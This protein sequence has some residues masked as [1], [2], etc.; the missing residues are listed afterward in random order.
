M[1][2]RKN[3]SLL[4][5]ASVITTEQEFNDVVGRH[6]ATAAD[7]TVQ[8]VVKFNPDFVYARFKAIGC[9]CVDGPNANADGFPYDQFLDSRAGYG[10]QSFIGK[11]AFVEH[12]SDNINNAI[13]NL[14]SA[15]LNRF[16]TSKYSNKEWQL[17]NGT[18]RHYVL[19]NR[20][21]HEDGSVEVLMAIDRQ[22]S[23]KIA[24]MLETES[25]VGCSMGTNIDYS[26]CT[27]CGNRAYVEENYC[28]HIKFSKG[29]NVLVP[30][31]QISELIKKG[32]IKTE[33]LPFILYR[34]QDLKAVASDVRRMVY[35]KAFEVNYGLSFFELS[36]VANP[37]FHRGYKLEKIASTSKKSFQQLLPL[38]YS[39]EGQPIEVVLNI[40]DGFYK[41]VLEAFA[42][43]IGQPLDQWTGEE[44]L[45]FERN[46]EIAKSALQTGNVHEVLTKKINAPYL[47]KEGIDLVPSDDAGFYQISNPDELLTRTFA[48]TRLRSI[49]GVV[50]TF[51]ESYY[52]CAICHGVYDR[53]SHTKTGVH[54]WG[55]FN[56]FSVCPGCEQISKLLE[57]N[58][59]EV[60]AMAKDRSVNNNLGGK[61]AAEGTNLPTT[62][63][64]T[65]DKEVTI[66]DPRTKETIL[67]KGWAAKGSD[68]IEKEK[69][70]RPM[71]TIFIDAIVARKDLNDR[72]AR[73]AELLKS[74]GTLLNRTKLALDAPEDFLAEMGE[75]KPPELD[76]PKGV[77][78]PV[79]PEDDM[80]IAIAIDIESEGDLRTT[81]E[82]TKADLE[83]IL[84]DLE[85]AKSMVG[86]SEGEAIDA[87][88]NKLRWGKRQAIAAQKV[89][90]E[91]DSLIEDA[92]SA[93]EDA[94]DK[95]QAACEFLY[96]EEGRRPD[97]EKGADSEKVEEK[98]NDTEPSDNSGDKSDGD[99]K[100]GFPFDK[101]DGKKYDNTN[102]K[103]VDSEGGDDM[104]KKEA[105]L[106]LN[107]QNI[108]LLRDLRDVVVGSS[109][110]TKVAA[111]ETEEV[112][113]E[114]AEEVEVSDKVTD[115]ENTEKEASGTK[116]TKSADVKEAAAQPPTGARDPGDY[117][118]PGAIETFEMKRWWQDMYPEFEKMKATE[119]RTELNIPEGKVELLT[120]PLGPREESDPEVGKQTDAPT[121]FAKR[122]ANTWE[123]KKS[124]YGVLK[125]AED[126]AVEAFTANFTDVTDEDA[127]KEQF[128]DFTSDAYMDE[129]VDTVKEHGVE[130]TRKIMNGKTAQ[131]EGITPGKTEKVNPLY[132]TDE[133]KKNS[134]SPREGE[135]PDPK[136]GHGK[137][138]SN[139]KAYYA[140]AYGDEGYASDLVTAQKKVASLTQEVADLKM[141]QSSDLIAKHALHLARV[142]SSRGL[143]PF[144]LTNIQSQ[145][146]DYIKYDE[147]SI[148]AVKAHLEKL[149]VVNQRALEAYQIPEA[150]D[151]S[152]GV[153]H[154]SLDAVDRIRMEHTNAEKVAPDGIQ[155]A[156]ES[157]AA[158]TAEQKVHISKK[159]SEAIVPQMHADSA[160]DTGGLP[161]MSKYFTNTI[162]NRLRAAGK[163]DECIAKGWL[164]SNRR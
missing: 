70:Y 88:A 111:D 99:S 158:L 136:E 141:D 96:A 44:R 130:A 148:N 117:G 77:E 49:A 52:G 160:A 120:G 79:G 89:A 154:N 75:G 45:L 1:A 131:L 132:D 151:M 106:E 59:G 102:N 56:K 104:P 19:A 127:G 8:K 91:A 64:F 22:L 121:I 123:P 61:T 82:N 152:S 161:D 41:S 101:K 110:L 128:D 20:N 9:L 3:A 24:R 143:I 90:T 32:T 86:S 67:Y 113:V 65:G 118:E 73:I 34:A 69:E 116:A 26:E 51:E 74:A 42:N 93:V 80:G 15:Y 10:Y 134:N 30:A 159:A 164:K 125:V 115:E 71:G 153:I 68:Q 78:G 38:I 29:Q 31:G 54:K 107:P 133:E 85:Q 146:M 23:P 48:G 6:T 4:K 12:G 129:I 17:L 76:V 135:R 98:S 36:V 109:S 2:L 81:L 108:Q 156:V 72:S 25:P 33:W 18:E 124:F 40:T 100:G 84:A 55:T 14:H 47:V 27:I 57:N 122:F 147:N 16:N 62:S 119:Q 149:P 126:G 83:L 145:A 163:L 28:P 60:Y 13:G 63:E 112:K 43:Q 53:K 138:V 35:A 11:H 150:E 142:A 66:G 21:P 155:P 103:K 5:L 144:D 114:E 92:V 7:H 58:E 157:N 87:L 97:K 94:M 46:G 162:E 95:L 137:A 50:G 140:K 105:S 139:D 37:A 39:A